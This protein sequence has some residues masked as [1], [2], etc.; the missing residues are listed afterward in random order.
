MEMEK[1]LKSL[2]DISPITMEAWK[3]FQLLLSPLE[4][5]RNEYLVR[6]GSG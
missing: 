6:E 3:D 5:E 2:N 4:V 1:I